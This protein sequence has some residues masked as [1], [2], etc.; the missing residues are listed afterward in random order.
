MTSKLLGL[1]N[2]Q[3]LAKDLRFQGPWGSDGGNQN[4]GNQDNSGSTKPNDSRPNNSGANNK[5]GNKTNQIP[6]DIFEKAEKFIKNL[7][8][9]K[10]GGSGNGSNNIFKGSNGKTPKSL[11]GLIVLALVFIWLSSGI[12]KVNSDENAVVLYFGKFYS[13]E[14]PGLNYHIPFPFGQVIKKS[15]TIVNTE[16]FGFA[17]NSKKGQPRNLDAE[18]LM[19]TGDENIVDIEFQVQWQIADI[20][21]FVFNIAETNLAIRKTA[22]SAMREVIART[23]IANALSDGKRNIELATKDLLQQILDGYGAGVR[24]VLVQ[25]RR[26][27]P[28]SQVIDAFRDVQTAKA[29]KE[30]EINQAQS[31]ANDIIPR[32]RGLSAEMKQQA[33]AFRQEVIANAQGE[34]GR[35]LSVYNQYAKAKQV[36]RKR[37]YLET[38]EKIYGDMDKVIIDKNASKAGVIPYFPLND[39]PKQP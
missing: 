7:F 19:L 32:A 29:D 5:T 38:M 33:E 24:I 4:G 20:K 3:N 25:L 13:I 8:D 37:M 23:P 2:L 31:Y 28:P 11:I 35:F 15:V 12:Y 21:D 26:V 17:S 18:S 27:D 30:K 36:T 16:E 39:M 6:E 34:A 14:T 9:N 10:S 1:K 22:E